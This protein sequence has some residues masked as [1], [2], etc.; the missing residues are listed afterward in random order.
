MRMR[1]PFLLIFLIILLHSLPAVS[2]VH[3]SPAHTFDTK[4]QGARANTNPY[5]F[6]YTCGSG[7]TLF[8]LSIVVGGTTARAGGAPTYNSVA[9]TQADQNRIASSGETV[10]ELWYLLSPPTGSAYTVSIPNTGAVYLSPVASSYKSATGQ[11]AL[12]TANGGTG[13]STNPTGP[14]LTGLVSGDVIIAVVG[15]GAQTWAPTGRTGTQLYDRDDGSYGNGAQYLIKTD[16]TNVAMGWTFGT[17]DDWAICEAAFKEVT[18]TAPVNGAGSITD[19]DD[20]NNLYA[21][22]KLYTSSSV[23]NDAD[24]WNDATK[25]INYVEFRLKQGANTRAIFRYTVGTAT[26]STPTGSTTW[27]LD[28]S[29]SASGSGTQLTMTWK[30][31][32]KW[33]ATEESG[34]SIELYT[35][36]QGGLSDTDTAQPSY[37]DIV[38]TLTVSGFASDPATYVQPS[39]SVTF[40]GTVYYVNNPASSTPS[41]FYPPNAEFTAVHIHNSAHASQGS[42]TTIV[43]GA[44]SLAITAPATPGVYTYH[45][46]IDMADADYA[47]GDVSGVTDD[48]TVVQNVEFAVAG[49]LNLLSLSQKT[50]SLAFSLGQQ[51]SLFDS[52]VVNRF[53]SKSVAD[54]LNLLSLAQKA[55]QAFQFSIAQK[56]NLLETLTVNKFLSKSATDTLNLLSSATKS[57]SSSKSVADLLTL[58]SSAVASTPAIFSVAD[59]LALSAIDVA[60]IKLNNWILALGGGGLP[61]SAGKVVGVEFLQ[62]TGVLGLLAAAVTAGYIGHLASERGYF[63]KRRRERR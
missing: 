57:I 47:D 60:V 1:S 27:D 15:T 38:V 5:T 51:Q 16:S 43:N 7:T 34:L 6:S 21:Q 46:Y 62:V 50:S 26:F 53:L 61:P 20:S 39:S 54:T 30:F 12:K 18:N 59:K 10:A 23:H 8:V 49:K 29:S 19:M 35:I 3:A 63:K 4:Y 32:P 13:T 58:F 45:P 42:D 9:M 40:S 55:A 56:Q 17:S 31:T 36:D 41:T 22:K 24:G 37:C 14:T 28:A 52:M 25:G 2:P 44:F 11:S 48:I 33:G